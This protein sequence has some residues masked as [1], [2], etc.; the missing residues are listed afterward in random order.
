LGLI[1]VLQF[2]NAA[3]RSPLNNPVNPTATFGFFS[4]LELNLSLP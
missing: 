3:N 4:R 2:L 1:Q